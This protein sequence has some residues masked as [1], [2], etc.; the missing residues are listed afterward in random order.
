MWWQLH[1]K[2][3]KPDNN[4]CLCYITG[5]ASARSGHVCYVGIKS[6]TLIIA[7]STFLM[8]CQSKR[9]FFYH[10]SQVCTGQNSWQMANRGRIP[11]VWIYK[12]IGR[13]E[14]T[15]NQDGDECL[16]RKFTNNEV[17]T[18]LTMAS[19]VPSQTPVKG[20]SV[21]SEPSAWDAL[22]EQRSNRVSANISI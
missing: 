20:L 3:E 18:W 22:R 8:A 6:L 19:P 15:T 17:H 10:S 9:S 4:C 16:K 7:V 14:V 5:L 2:G 11:K 21:V 1:T 13:N 12:Q